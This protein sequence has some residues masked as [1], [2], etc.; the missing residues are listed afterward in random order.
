MD[1]VPVVEGAMLKWSE[2]PDWRVLN[3]CASDFT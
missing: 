2:T 1:L 3:F